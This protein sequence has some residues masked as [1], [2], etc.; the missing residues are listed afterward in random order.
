MEA[1][2]TIFIPTITS[3]ERGKETIRLRSVEWQFKEIFSQTLP[4]RTFEIPNKGIVQKLIFGTSFDTRKIDPRF[5]FGSFDVL[6]LDDKTL[7]TT[8]TL[9]TEAQKVSDLSTILTEERINIRDI[10]TRIAIP[11]YEP[12]NRDWRWLPPNEVDLNLYDP[13]LCDMLTDK[14][15]PLFQKF[16][17]NKEFALETESIGPNTLYR[18]GVFVIESN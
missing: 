17:L 15:L 6:N 9:F 10:T 12:L 5:L 1:L 8:L 11:L 3:S 2:G 4:K 7:S 14:S 16:L 18:E 13:N